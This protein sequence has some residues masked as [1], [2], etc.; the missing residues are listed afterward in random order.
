MYLM[1]AER[2]W[3]TDLVAALLRATIVDDVCHQVVRRSVLV[4]GFQL[5]TDRKAV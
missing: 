2:G 3:A 4:L 1:Q 5:N